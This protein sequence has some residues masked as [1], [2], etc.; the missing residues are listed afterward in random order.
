MNEGVPIDTYEAWVQIVKII[1]E[2]Y[3]SKYQSK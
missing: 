3:V 2:N 1:V